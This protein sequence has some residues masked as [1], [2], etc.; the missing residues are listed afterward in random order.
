MARTRR[1]PDGIYATPGAVRQ[2]GGS[3]PIYICTTCQADVVWCESTRTGR[4]YLVTVRRGYNNQRFYVGN[5]I[6]RCEPPTTT[7]TPEPTTQH[8]RWLAGH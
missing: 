2:H 7:P 3:L 5:D 1:S 4:R 8:A 6:H